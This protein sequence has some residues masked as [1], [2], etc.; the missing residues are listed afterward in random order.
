M[1]SIQS[2][3]AQARRECDANGLPAG[4]YTYTNKCADQEAYRA[5]EAVLSPEEYAAKK[6]AKEAK[7]KA[8][9]IARSQ[10]TNEELEL[11]EGLV[12]DAIKAHNYKGAAWDLAGISIK[13][14]GLKS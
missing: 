1:R 2:L 10:L 4:E 5:I 3:A 14:R 6:A 8:A 13:L 7:E 11:L 12:S 9:R